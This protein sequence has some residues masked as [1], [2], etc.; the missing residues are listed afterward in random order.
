[1]EKLVSRQAHNLK[2]AGPSPVPATNSFVVFPPRGD[3]SR[4]EVFKIKTTIKDISS[5][6]MRWRLC[7]L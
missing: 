5:V 7:P 2:I 3:S 4:E 6:E 1:M